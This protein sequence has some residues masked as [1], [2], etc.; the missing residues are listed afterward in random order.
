VDIDPAEINKLAPYI[1]TPIC[2][3]AGAFLREML[4]QAGSIH[5]KDR[6]CWKERCADWKTRYPLVLEEHRKAEGRVSIFYLSEVIS[7]ETTPEDLM[8]SGSPGSGIE[9]FLFACPTRTGQ[10]I[11]H[12]AGLGS[13][14][15][16]LPGSIGV[17]IAGGRRRTVCV[18][19]DGGFQFNIQELE[20][21]ARLK[22]P[23]KYFVLNNDGYA[24]IRASQE[25]F[26]GSAQIGCDRSNGVTIPDLCKV[27]AA[28]GLA[29]ERI[30]SQANLRED[31]RRVLETP[32]PVVCDVEVIPDEVR[33]PRVSSMKR[34]D[35]SLVPKPLEDL[36]PFLPREEFLANMIV[37]PLEE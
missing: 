34:A 1:H 37:A 9:I 18:D 14:G 16:A 36:W 17:C 30:T 3:D 15:N 33:G 21:V 12:T 28:Y 31:V 27:A 32:G 25:N 6:T 5:P 23:I 11:Y 35:G 13:M 24:S 19:G 7:H 10:R 2:A 26:F 22:L 20:T 8:I 4:R 29:A